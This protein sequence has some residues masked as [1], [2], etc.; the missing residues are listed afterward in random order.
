MLGV[1][2]SV[3]TKDGDNRQKSRRIFDFITIYLL[4]AFY[5]DNYNGRCL[6]ITLGNEL[7]KGICYD[8]T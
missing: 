5:C 2:R 8:N 3:K 4:M 1:G 6:L 7:T